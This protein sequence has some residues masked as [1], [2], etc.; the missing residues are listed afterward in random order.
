M[1][2]SESLSLR[3][4]F[5]RGGSHFYCGFSKGV[6]QRP[7]TEYA[8]ARVKEKGVLFHKILL[9]CEVACNLAHFVYEMTFGLPNVPVWDAESH[10]G[11]FKDKIKIY[12]NQKSL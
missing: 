6:Q 5:K 9:E 7:W 2:G 4:G 8:P 3:R 11:L 1:S 10:E 12:K